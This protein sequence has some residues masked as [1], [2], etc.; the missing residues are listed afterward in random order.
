M[1]ATALDD[2]SVHVPLGERVSAHAF[3]LTILH[4][5]PD[6]IVRELLEMVGGDPGPLAWSRDR[7]TRLARI[8][9]DSA[10]TDRAAALATLAWIQAVAKR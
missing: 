8:H 2:A 5:P 10:D 4:E 9:E 7:L 1:N 6:S 3:A